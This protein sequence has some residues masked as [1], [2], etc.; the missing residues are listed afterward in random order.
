MDK[1]PVS[2]R[3]GKGKR[4]PKAVDNIDPLRTS[5]TIP[6]HIQEQLWDLPPGCTSHHAG[7]LHLCLGLPIMLR[8]NEATECGVTNGAEGIVVGWKSHMSESR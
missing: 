7:R 2:R 8:Q 3:K 6:P 1:F 5:N 4:K